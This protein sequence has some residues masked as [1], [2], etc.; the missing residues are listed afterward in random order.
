[1]AFIPGGIAGLCRQ[2]WQRFAAVKPLR[3]EQSHG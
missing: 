1:V 2:V 3:P